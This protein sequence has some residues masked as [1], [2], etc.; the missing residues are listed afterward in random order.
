MSCDM[1]WWRTSE[2]SSADAHVRRQCAASRSRRH[3]PRYIGPMAELPWWLAASECILDEHV[4]AAPAEVRE[5]YVDL[6]N[7]ITVHPLVVSVTPEPPVDT[8]DGYSQRYRV[9]DRI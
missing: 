8:V 5:F 9:R 6:R 7:T 3:G 1:R 4:P 2:P